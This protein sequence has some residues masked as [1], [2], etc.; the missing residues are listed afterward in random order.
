MAQALPSSFTS[1][2]PEVA[3]LTITVA[4]LEVQVAQ[5]QA[6]IQLL[7]LTQRRETLIRQTLLAY[8]PAAEVEQYVIDLD[9]GLVRRRDQPEPQEGG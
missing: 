1:P 5:L 8:V 4:H 2:I 3:L 6:Q 9:S 7:Q